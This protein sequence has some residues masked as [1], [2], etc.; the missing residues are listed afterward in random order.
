MSFMWLGKVHAIL[1][2]IQIVQAFR[3]SQTTFCLQIVTR[4]TKLEPEVGYSAAYVCCCPTFG[5]RS[6]KTGES[7]PFSSQKKHLQMITRKWDVSSSNAA[8]PPTAINSQIE[9]NKTDLRNSFIQAAEVSLLYD[10][11][12]GF[13]AAL[14]LVLIGLRHQIRV[15]QQ[16]EKMISTARQ[17][18]K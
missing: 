9:R 14:E 16:D 7:L 6:L 2:Q 3:E 8:E 15:I 5:S 17:S 13:H 11:V 10:E 18:R 4:E 1:G 12:N